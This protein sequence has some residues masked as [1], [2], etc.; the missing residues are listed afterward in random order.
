MR[1]VAGER[2]GR[3]E[4][5]V[6]FFMNE[7]PLDGDHVFRIQTTEIQVPRVANLYYY[8]GWLSWSMPGLR[9]QVECEVDIAPQIYQNVAEVFSLQERVFSI[10]FS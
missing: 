3:V 10:E 4:K 6:N 2:G 5:G 8:I 9:T 1:C 7:G